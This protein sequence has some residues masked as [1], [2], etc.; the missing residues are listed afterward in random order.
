MDTLFHRDERQERLATRFTKR[1]R[2]AIGAAG[3]KW[4]LGCFPNVTTR[5]MATSEYGPICVSV[6]SSEEPAI[7][8]TLWPTRELDL[9]EL[10]RMLCDG[11][12]ISGA[13]KEEDGE[14]Q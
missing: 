13:L 14:D 11:I 3:A 9:G 8:L 5:Y 1:V 2:K 6:N 4:G 7:A 12:H 10:E